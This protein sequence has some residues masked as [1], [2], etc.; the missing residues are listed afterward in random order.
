MTT[1]LRLGDDLGVD[2]A[3]VAVIVE[4][5]VD[6]HDEEI[7]DS[8]ATELR[9]VLNPCGERGGLPKHLELAMAVRERDDPDRDLVDQL[10]T[11]GLRLV[12]HALTMERLLPPAEATPYTKQLDAWFDGGPQPHVLTFGH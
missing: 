4:S 9:E 3:D 11:D 8:I 7:P 12:A 10:Y 1:L 2:A 6:L 5:I